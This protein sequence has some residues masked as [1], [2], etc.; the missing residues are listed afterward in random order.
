MRDSRG[1]LILL[2]VVVAAAVVVWFATRTPGPPAPVPTPAEP[3]TDTTVRLDFDDLPV[4]SPDLAVGPARV[5]VAIQDGFSSWSVIIDCA[6]PEGCAG[7]LA[8]RVDLDAGDDERQVVLAGRVDVP[9]GGELHFE[10]LQDPATPVAGIN[11]VSLEVRHRVSEADV[12]SEPL[13]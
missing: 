4:D 10:G 2:T 12:L 6:E 7:E 13:Q 8:A 9:A 1:L 3:E 5:R 11:R